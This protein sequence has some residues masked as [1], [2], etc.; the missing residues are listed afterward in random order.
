MGYLFHRCKVTRFFGSH[1]SLTSFLGADAGAG[2]V[3]GRRNKTRAALPGKSGGA[4]LDE[5][6]L[7]DRIGK[8]FRP[9]IGEANTT[10]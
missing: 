9:A 10:A 1:A 8:V 5:A 4:R 2:L 7:Q 6:G 3:F